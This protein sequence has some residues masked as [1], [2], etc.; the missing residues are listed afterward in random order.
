MKTGC[1]NQNIDREAVAIE[2]IQRK[3][4]LYKGQISKVVMIAFAMFT[5]VKIGQMTNKNTQR[6][7]TSAKV[8]P[9]ILL[10]ECKD[11][12]KVFKKFLDPD[13]HP[14]HHQNLIICS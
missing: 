6:A 14:R 9:P 7:Y 4:S 3:Y 13:G 2:K 10:S 11:G 5:R 12:K 1:I 8:T